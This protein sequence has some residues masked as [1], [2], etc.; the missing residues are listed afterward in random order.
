MMPE[1]SR[2]RVDD[3]LVIYD[4]PGGHQSIRVTEL[5]LEWGLVGCPQDPE[6]PSYTARRKQDVLRRAI[7]LGP[8]PHDP[9]WCEKCLEEREAPGA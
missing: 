8:A 2:V 1:T 9:N 6:K 5:W 4:L 7:L 3:W